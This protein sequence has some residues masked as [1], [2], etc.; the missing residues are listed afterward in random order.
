MSGIGKP[1][2]AHACGERAQRKDD[3]TQEGALMHPEKVEAGKRHTP[4]VDPVP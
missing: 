1:C 3:S 2:K 4:N